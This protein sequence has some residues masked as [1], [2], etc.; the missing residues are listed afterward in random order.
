MRGKTI[1]VAEDD[2]SIR[3]LVRARLQISGYDVVT[4]RT[5]AEAVSRVRTSVVDGLILD[6]NMPEV[7]GFGVLRAIQETPG[8]RRLPVLMLT[9]RHAHDDVRRAVMLGARDYLTKP[10]S[11]QQLIARVARLLKPRFEP[12]PGHGAI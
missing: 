1:L 10:F 7:D 8:I 5:G 11:E 4:A 3:E 6:I 12:P 2:S 9:A